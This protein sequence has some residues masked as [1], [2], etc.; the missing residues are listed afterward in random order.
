MRPILLT[1]SGGQHIFSNKLDSKL[2]IR[3]FQGM[4]KTILFISHSATRTGAPTV[5]LHLLTW[6]KQHADVD[7]KVLVREKGPLLTDFEALA[8]TVNLDSGYLRSLLQIAKRRG[9]V[10]IE[11][12]LY[13]IVLHKHY[14]RGSIALICSNTVTNHF[15][16]EALSY[17]NCPVV[18][19]VHELE[20]WIREHIGLRWFEITK[21]KTD[22]FIAVSEPVRQNLIENHAIQAEQ[23][24]MIPEFIPAIKIARSINAI[25]R[26]KIRRELAIPSD[27]L[28]VGSMGWIGWNKG[29]DLFVQSACKVLDQVNYPVYFLWVGGNPSDL[30][31]HPL[32]EALKLNH[33]QNKILFVGE[34]TNPLDY[35]VAMDIFCLPSRE[36][37]FPLTMLEAAACGLPIICFDNSGGAPYFV[38]TDAGLTIPYEDTN[39]MANGI[40]E[41][42]ESEQKRK[43][44]GRRAQEKVING[45]DID[46]NAPRLLGEIEKHFR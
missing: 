23:I 11:R 4:Q 22:H 26:Q 14:P 24:S 32:A 2:I 20:T 5:M 7:F 12:I 18:S 40:I 33:H 10:G 15:V 45:Y 19:I 39:A 38:E 36:D 17:L 35:M 8:Q 16:L 6:M 42:L 27:A 28:V 43:M 41:L 44:F 3:I 25:T 30:R 9:L 31:Y 46:Q 13:P 37:S 29:P 34:K 21:A 1:H